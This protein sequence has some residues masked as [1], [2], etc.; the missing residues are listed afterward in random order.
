LVPPKAK[1]TCCRSLPRCA[2]CPVVLA[3]RARSQQRAAGR[4][5]LVEEFLIGRPARPLPEPV[6]AALD[7]LVATRA[8]H[9]RAEPPA[10]AR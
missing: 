5:A 4:A 6:R 3:A 1:T 9:R 2:G 7:Q 8:S 10:L